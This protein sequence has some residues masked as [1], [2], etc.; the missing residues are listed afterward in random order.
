MLKYLTTSHLSVPR[1]AGNTVGPGRLGARCGRGEGGPGRGE[2]PGLHGLRGAVHAPQSRHARGGGA[3]RRQARCPPAAGLGRDRPY[4]QGVPV[5]LRHGR[6]SVPARAT[7]WLA[8]T[9]APIDLP[10]HGP[11]HA[12]VGCGALQR[13]RKLVPVRAARRRGKRRFADR[14]R[15]RTA[16]PISADTAGEAHAGRSGRSVASVSRGEQ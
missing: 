14:S 15:R 9:L 6:E 1:P 5:A 7:R 2:V 12:G 4:G 13:D 11:L 8:L 10:D 16:S 3:S